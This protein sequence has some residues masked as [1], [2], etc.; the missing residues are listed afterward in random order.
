[1]LNGLGAL[2]S[3]GIPKLKPVKSIGKTHIRAFFT[4]TKTTMISGLNFK[5]YN[6]IKVPFFSTAV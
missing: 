2:F 6:N 5:R 4:H 3:D 1:M